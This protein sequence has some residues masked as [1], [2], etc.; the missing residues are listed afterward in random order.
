MFR[1]T[2]S[3]GS[4]FFLMPSSPA[5]KVTASARYGLQA[6]SGF[7]SSA[8]VP[9]PLLAGMRTSG[10]LFFSDQAMYTGAS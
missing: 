5:F 1:L 2:G 8:R 9:S 3:P 4:I 6:G 10:D 7:L